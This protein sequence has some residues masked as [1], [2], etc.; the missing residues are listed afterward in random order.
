MGNQRTTRPTRFEYARHWRWMM[1]GMLVLIPALTFAWWGRTAYPDTFPPLVEDLDRKAWVQGAQTLFPDRYQQFHDK[2]LK[3]R[4]EWRTEVNHWW[5][6]GDAAVFNQTYQQLVE[7]GS[8][9]I[10]AA[11]QKS[12]AFRQEVEELLQPEQAQLTRLRTLSKFFDLESDMPALSKA[13]GLLRESAV[14]LQQGQ[15]LQARLAGEQAL[16]HLHQV[17]THA[18]TQMKRY[19]SDAQITRWEQWVNHTIR[20]SSATAGTAVVVLKAPRRLLM[21]HRG[22]IIADYP[23]SLGFSGLAD[24]LSEG[25]GATPEGQF[26]VI[27]KKE[28]PATK[29]YKA[30]LLDYPT[31]AHQQRFHEAKTN[32]RLPAD[33]SIGS[34]IEIHGESSDNEDATSGCIALENSAMDQVYD[35]S[36]TKTPVTIVGALNT[37]NEVVN[38]LH[39][40]E[41]HIRQRTERWNRTGSLEALFTRAK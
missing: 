14:R 34:L 36:K 19:T 20:W 35:R 28:G 37:D 30:L 16:A 31:V 13:E 32:G 41:E 3:L 38:T 24:K 4:A 11:R 17:E 8:L 7:E 22:R 29:Y 23:V 9:L 10:E 25:D 18:M 21:Y 2:V 40:L 33:R 39:L 6:N 5:S 12:T 15:Y 1:T 27:H 26:Y